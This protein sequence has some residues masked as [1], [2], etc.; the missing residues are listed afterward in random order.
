MWYGELKDTLDVSGTSIIVVGAKADKKK[1]RAV[2]TE[3]AEAVAQ[4][5]GCPYME[6]S[7]ATGEGV[8]ELFQALVTSI[9]E[10]HPPEQPQRL[11]LDASKKDTWS[12]AC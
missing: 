9:R 10:K 1:S 6:T 5:L 11:K 4:S 2:S 8:H 7:S 12:C 3:E